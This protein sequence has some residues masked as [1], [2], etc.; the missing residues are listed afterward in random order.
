MTGVS[1]LFE[2]FPLGGLT[3]KNRVTMT[4]LYLGYAGPD[5]SVTPLLLDH[6]R[7][8]AASGA[9]LIAVEHTAVEES[10]LGSP[11][12]LRADDDRY[13][14]GLAELARTIKGQGALA[15]LQLNHCGRYAYLPE[16][17]APWPLETRGVVPRALDRRDITRLVRAYAAAAGRVKAAGFDGVEIHGGTGY[18]P[19]QFLSARTNKRTDEYGGTLENRMR[20]PLE[21]IEAVLN[22]VGRDFPVGY[23]FIADE[24][25]PDGLKVEETAVFA[26]RL[27]KTWLAY[28]SVIAG[29][30]DSF[31]L[32]DYLQKERQ[33]GYMASYAAEIKKAAPDIP[34]ITAGRLQTPETAARIIV[35]GRADLI[36][37]AR[38]L[39]ADPLWPRKAGGEIKEPI[40]ICE[41]T[42]S[43][44]QK[45]TWSGRPALCAQWPRAKREAFLRRVG[46]RPE[47]AE[48]Y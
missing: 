33:E 4:P 36:G 28:L 2:P 38:V 48:Q 25:L 3:L 22:E 37:L 6:Y 46:E 1:I 24:L 17:L 27:E 20:F 29:T 8:M 26:A 5:G 35:E 21:V 31:I 32:P 14:P 10:G 47:E 41:P 30:Y 12:M 13:L 23:R 45:R 7:E 11:F 15:F 44:C 18:L 34:V 42:C 9:A 40:T 43:L 39:L 19:V 16:R